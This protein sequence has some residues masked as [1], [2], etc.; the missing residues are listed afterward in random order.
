MA[1]LRALSYLICRLPWPKVRRTHYPT[2]VFSTAF[3]LLLALSPSCS[4]AFALFF[5]WLMRLG[6]SCRLGGGTS[7]PGHLSLLSFR[8]S[9]ARLFLAL[10]FFVIPP[11]PVPFIFCSAIT[12][13][14]LL[15]C[16]GCR[17]IVVWLLSSAA[18][19]WCSAS[20]FLLSLPLSGCSVFVFWCSFGMSL[21]LPRLPV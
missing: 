4:S 7:A 9:P 13:L 18:L 16:V 3:L 15:F 8:F 1:R 14:I 2:P 12:F 11:P 6:F 10:C 19:E 17:W 20:L 5:S 21:I